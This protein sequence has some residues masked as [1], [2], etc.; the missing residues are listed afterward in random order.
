MWHRKAMDKEIVEAMATKFSENFAI[1]TIK[2]HKKI[3]RR[4]FDS[5][6]CHTYFQKSFR[7]L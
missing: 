3:C 7:E 5:F 2:K 4:G 1:S 6:G